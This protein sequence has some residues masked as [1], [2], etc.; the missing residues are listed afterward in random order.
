MSD[1]KQ[2]SGA[3]SDASDTEPSTSITAHSNLDLSSVTIST[4]SNSSATIAKAKASAD[5]AKAMT[6]VAVEMG[7]LSSELSNMKLDPGKLVS[8]TIV[9]GATPVFSGNDDNSV[10]LPHSP[11]RGRRIEFEGGR[12]EEKVEEDNSKKIATLRPLILINPNGVNDD[13]EDGIDTNNN[14]RVVKEDVS[15]DVLHNEYFKICLKSKKLIV[16]E[17]MGKAYRFNHNN[18]AHLFVVPAD[19]ALMVDV[20]FL[21]SEGKALNYSSEDHFL[22]CRE[23]DINVLRN[24]YAETDDKFDTKIPSIKDLLKECQKAL[25]QVRSTNNAI[26][27]NRI[28]KCLTKKDLNNLWKLKKTKPATVHAKGDVRDI[29]KSLGA[30]YLMNNVDD[31]VTKLLRPEFCIGRCGSARAEKITQ[32][33]RN[34]ISKHWTEDMK[35]FGVNPEK[36]TLPYN[37]QPPQN[38]PTVSP[39]VP[40]AICEQVEEEMRQLKEE[41]VSQLK[42]AGNH[43]EKFDEKEETKEKKYATVESHE[44][45][46]V[47][48]LCTFVCTLHMIRYLYDNH[49]FAI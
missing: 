21:L 19:C 35:N 23:R 1:N 34:T 18:K 49:T 12:E 4:N 30:V 33:F 17:T 26:G 24:N 22:R 6:A 45:D 41:Y 40:E 7:N 36:H 37:Y 10:H 46:E 13:E 47:S 39:E 15:I 27:K 3:R 43:D 9:V 14:N 32:H 44:K 16:K 11:L 31:P 5:A 20:I 8:P 48:S 38:N 29:I 42:E 2:S 28:K 25:T